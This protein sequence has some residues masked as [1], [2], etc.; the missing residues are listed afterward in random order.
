MVRDTKPICYVLLKQSQLKLAQ[1]HEKFIDGW[2]A[3]LWLFS[4]LATIPVAQSVDRVSKKFKT[5][6]K[7]SIIWEAS[8]EMYSI[9]V[10]NQFCYI[11]HSRKQWMWYGCVAP[12]RTMRSYVCISSIECSLCVG[13]ITSL[14][15]VKVHILM[16]KC[17]D[18]DSVQLDSY[19]II[20][21]R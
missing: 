8:I 19:V 7:C 13:M 9:V 21:C 4:R 18:H 2:G 20:M 6:Y 14:T 3:P 16:K 17:C 10:V 5:R 12:C 11:M 15:A 1:N